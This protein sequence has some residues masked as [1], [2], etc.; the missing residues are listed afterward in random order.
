MRGWADHEREALI[1]SLSAVAEDDAVDSETS[2]LLGGQ[3][4]RD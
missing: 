4:E 3:S 1:F 2:S